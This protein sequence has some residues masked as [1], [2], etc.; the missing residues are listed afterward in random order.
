VSLTIEQRIEVMRQTAEIVKNAA[1]NENLRWR[2]EDLVK[3]TEEI[4]RKM[5]ELVQR[6][7]GSRSSDSAAGLTGRPQGAATR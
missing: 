2:N 6:D 4:Y 1:A 7:D 3:V 5:L